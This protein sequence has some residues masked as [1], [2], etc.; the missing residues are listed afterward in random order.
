[1]LIHFVAVPWTGASVDPAR[2]FGPALVTNEWKD[3]WIYIVGP[4]LGGLLGGFLY[5]TLK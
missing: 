3:F 1:M 2:S 5:D 4:I